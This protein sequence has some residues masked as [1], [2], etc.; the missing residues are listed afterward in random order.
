[1]GATSGTRTNPSG[2]HGYTLA[3]IGVSFDQSL[4]LRHAVMAHFIGDYMVSSSSILRL[5]IIALWY[6]QT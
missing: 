6:L 4:I 5:L 2:A 1:M 3:F